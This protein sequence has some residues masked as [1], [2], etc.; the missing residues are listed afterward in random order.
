MSA[1]C[2]FRVFVPL[3]LMSGAVHLGYLDLA[4]NFAW[5][6]T[7]RALVGLG[8][9]TLAEVLAYAIP[10]L[11]NALDAIASPAAVV[12]GAIASASVLGDASPFV[13][14]TLAAIAGGGVAGLV[15]GGTVATRA[16]S[17][18]GTGGLGNILVAAGE[19]AASVGTALLAMAAPFVA[20]ALVGVLVVVLVRQIVRWRRRRSMHQ[21]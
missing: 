8:V 7:E 21:P 10:W 13:Q 5:M 3:F 6:E 2:G 9:A 17:T 14:W 12:A 20:L 11:D 16:A 4:P 19:V 15:Q 1:A 18:A